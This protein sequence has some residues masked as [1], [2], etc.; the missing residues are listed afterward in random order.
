MSEKIPMKRFVKPEESGWYWVAYAPDDLLCKRYYDLRTNCFYYD[1]NK[2]FPAAIDY[3]L[4]SDR[5][6]K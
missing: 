3:Y 5:V 2:T 6:E 1:K 4:I